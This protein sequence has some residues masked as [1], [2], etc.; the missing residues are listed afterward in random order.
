MRKQIL[1]IVY[2]DVYKNLTAHIRVLQHGS[3]TFKLFFIVQAIR[4]D[5]KVSL[6]TRDISVTQKTNIVSTLFLD[7]H[8]TYCEARIRV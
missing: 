4:C 1:C 5:R 3:K 2:V 8:D 6:S 7:D